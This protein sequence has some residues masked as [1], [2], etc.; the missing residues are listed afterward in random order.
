MIFITSAYI[1]TDRKD[2]KGKTKV[3]CTKEE[4]TY[5]RCQK[6]VHGTNAHG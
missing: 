5:R 6:E 1:F 3:A 2:A 4:I